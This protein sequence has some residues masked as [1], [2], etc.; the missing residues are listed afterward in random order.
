MLEKLLKLSGENGQ[1]SDEELEVVRGILWL[2]GLILGF[3]FMG[4]AGKNPDKTVNFLINLFL[5][6]LVAIGFIV[7]AY[8]I[9]VSFKDEN[10]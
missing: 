9:Y 10:H 6:L 2:A 7:L 8:C 4:I 3:F 1:W 5:F